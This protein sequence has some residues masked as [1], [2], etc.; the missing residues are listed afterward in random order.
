MSIMIICLIIYQ[1]CNQ[2]FHPFTV[3]FV[4]EET[5]SAKLCL[6]VGKENSKPFIRIDKILLKNVSPQT[7]H[8]IKK[9]PFPGVSTQFTA[10]KQSWHK[11]Q[12]V[13]HP[14]QNAIHRSYQFVCV[15]T[16]LKNNPSLLVPSYNHPW[17]T[18][19]NAT[20]HFSL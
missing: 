10:M 18:D 17:K 13:M 2:A 5:Y 14:V 8:T 12:K 16:G 15:G 11:L 19:I 3:N 20:Y 7:Q 4:T 9:K 6:G 1:L